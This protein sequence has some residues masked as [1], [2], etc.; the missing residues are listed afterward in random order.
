MIQ[1]IFQKI[2]EIHNNENQFNLIVFS[3]FNYGCLPQAL[4]GKIQTFAKENGILTF[5]DSQSS[6]QMGD[7]SR[8]KSA[9]LVTPTEREPGL[10]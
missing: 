10:L 1:K 2:Q 9:D 8:F 7:I 5:A 6:S 4:V 3:D